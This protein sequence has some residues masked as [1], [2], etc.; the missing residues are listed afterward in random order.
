[1]KNPIVLL[2]L[3]CSL[4]CASQ[5]TTAPE[6]GSPQSSPMVTYSLYSSAVKDTIVIEVTLPANYS[7]DSTT[8][9]SVL[10]LTDGYWRRGQHQ[11]IHDMAKNEDVKELIVVGIGYPDGYNANV[12]RVR[13]LINAPGVF[14]DFILNQLIPLIERT[15]RTTS[16]RT[17]WGSSYGGFFAMYSLFQYTANTKGVFQNYIVASPTVL[18]TTSY[19][20]TPTDLF[21]FEQILASSTTE[22]AVNLYVTVGGNEDPSQFVNPFKKLVNDLQGRNYTGFTMKWYIDPGKDHY[23][24]WE[25]TLY[26]GIR[27]FLKTS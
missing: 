12:V 17:L 23:T 8:A 9:Y 1:M 11:P 6:S 14:L 21:G 10:Y 4:S 16:E 3:L 18:Q 27:L 19:G 24:V 22:L 25:P 2:S 7:I 20:G 15:Y 5:H 13:D 26:E